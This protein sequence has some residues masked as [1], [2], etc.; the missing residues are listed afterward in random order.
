ML[1]GSKMAEATLQGHSA[2]GMGV[3]YCILGG[4]DEEKG[5]LLNILQFF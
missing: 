1:L 3:N 5:H 4:A 2:A